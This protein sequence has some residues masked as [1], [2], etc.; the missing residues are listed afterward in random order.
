LSIYAVGLPLTLYIDRAFM[1]ESLLALL[2]IACLRA[3]QVYLA[4]ARL[5]PLAVF[6]VASTLIAMVKPTYLI[7]WGPVVGLFI[8]RYGVRALGRP[9]L[10][11]VGAANIAAGVA[12]FS[13]ARDLGTLTGLSFG[14]TDKLFS[15]DLLLSADYVPKIVTRLVK[16]VLGPL[17]AVFLVVGAVGA[18]RRGRLAELAGLASFVVYLVVVTVGNFHHNYYQLPIVPIGTVLIAVGITEGVRRYGRTR[19]WSPDRVQLVCAAM[20]WVAACATFVR[21]ASAHNW[22]EIEPAIVYLCDETRAKLTPDD[23]VVII[24]NKSPALLFCLDKKGWILSPDEA[25][26]NRLSEVSREGADVL[27]FQEPVAGVESFLAGQTRLD[28][29]VGAFAVYRVSMATVNTM[30]R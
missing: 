18:A 25:T 17:G 24:G 14:V 27:V 21:S 8:E 9:E 6:V 30:G 10:W 26:P 28:V 22:Y 4:R 11:L 20:V 1:N 13:H 5:L 7:V 2:M 29:N 3:T 12:W 19:G 23:R 16:D 15:A